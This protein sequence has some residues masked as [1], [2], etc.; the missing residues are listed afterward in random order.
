MGIKPKNVIGFDI[1]GVLANS[2]PIIREGILNLY[3]ID[4]NAADMYVYDLPEIGV[5]HD[6]LLTSINKIIKDK[7]IL[8][9]PGVVDVIQRLYNILD[10]E[11]LIV[12]S[13][14][15]YIYQETQNWFSKW[16]PEVRFNI[17]FSDEKEEPILDNKCMVFV[18]DNIDNA[19]KISKCI[20][21]VYLMNRSWNSGP[22]EW[23]VYRET[24]YTPIIENYIIY[25][26]KQKTK[27]GKT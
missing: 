27:G 23:N 5:S 4:I 16:F 8:P 15:N 21:L 19:N 14:P 12:S 7:E 6:E 17:I 20:P 18:E 13:R 10:D 2:F 25:A 11:I 22:T 26:T 1:D 24:E 3:N 9:Y